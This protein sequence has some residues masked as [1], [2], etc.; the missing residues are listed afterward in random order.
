MVGYFRIK[1]TVASVV[2]RL[3]GRKSTSNPFSWATAFAAEI[4][5]G[6]EGFIPKIPSF[7]I[8]ETLPIP[9]LSKL[10]N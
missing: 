8:T 2:N 5:S 3:Y 6:A 10:I 9:K 1:V 4:S 7:V